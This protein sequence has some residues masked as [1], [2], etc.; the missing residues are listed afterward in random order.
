MVNVTMAPRPA[1]VQG[2]CES[3]STQAGGVRMSIYHQ[4]ANPMSGYIAQFA[5]H[6]ES[7]QRSKAEEKVVHTIQKIA[8]TS[9]FCAAA[10]DTNVRSWN[11][12]LDHI[13]DISNDH[14]EVRAKL[15]YSASGD[16]DEDRPFSGNR[17][18]GEAVAIIDDDEH[19]RYEEVTAEVDWTSELVVGTPEWLHFWLQKEWSPSRQSEAKHIKIDGHEVAVGPDHNNSSVWKYGIELKPPE[20]ITWRTR[21]YSSEQEAKK[22]ALQELAGVLGP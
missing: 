12:Y 14:V 16:S 2:H 17:I 1:D 5:N 22:A 11:V 21:E 10:T 15:V 8:D 20:Q 13:V 3:N 4:G 9:E 19:I 6:S 18:E 7:E